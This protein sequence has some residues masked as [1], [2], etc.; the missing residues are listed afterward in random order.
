MAVAGAAAAAAAAA[1]WSLVY[2]VDVGNT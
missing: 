2:V 1:E